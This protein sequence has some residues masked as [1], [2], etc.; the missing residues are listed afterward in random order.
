MA[1]KSKNPCDPWPFLVKA[2]LGCVTKKYGKALSP[3]CPYS[4]RGIGNSHCAFRIP[5]TAVMSGIGHFCRLHT[6]IGVQHFL[7]A[8][9]SA[10][11][12][13]SQQQLSQQAGLGRK[14]PEWP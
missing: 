12:R 10:C 6:W 5:C 7:L 9:G 2:A 3:P 1:V 4:M 8:R 13:H 14:V 11:P